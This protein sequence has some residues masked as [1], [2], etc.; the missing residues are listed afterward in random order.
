MKKNSKSKTQKNNIDVRKIKKNNPGVRN[1]N[2]IKI[3]PPI[4]LQYIDLK[5]KNKNKNKDPNREYTIIDGMKIKRPL[6]SRCL[7]VI[8]QNNDNKSAPAKRKQRPKK[9][10]SDIPLNNNNKSKIKKNT[11]N[12]ISRVQTRGGQIRTKKRK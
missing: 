11:N 10:L 6:Y 3:E 1:I 2:C 4:F 7:D 5:N 9:I 8:R 12:L